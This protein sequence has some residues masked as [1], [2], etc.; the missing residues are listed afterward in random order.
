MDQ[1]ALD[2]L[3][4][5]LDDENID[6]RMETLHTLGCTRDPRATAALVHAL[7]DP[8]QEIR[9]GAAEALD[10]IGWTPQGTHEEALLLSAKKDWAG[11][12][13]LDGLTPEG[14]WEQIRNREEYVRLGAIEALAATG[15]QQVADLLL[16]GV[17]EPSREVRAGAI[18][19]F[20]QLP[21]F[22]SETLL[23]ALLSP[24]RR[25]GASTGNGRNG[26]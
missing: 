17:C 25:T 9:S 5:S 1:K 3:L 4:A 10:R 19:G 7:A 15:N 2:V 21:S 23:L 26:P 22:S 8:H 24:D 16:Q 14:Y 12:L 18:K 13:A 11:L 20:L 6:I